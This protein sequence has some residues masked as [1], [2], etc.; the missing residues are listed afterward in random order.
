M[1]LFAGTQWDQPPRCE[2]CGELEEVCQ[3]P[4]PPAPRIP[5]EKQTAR[6]A[7]EKRK[8]GKLV[9]VVRGLPAEGNDL[10]ELLTKLKN[11][12]GAGGTLK[13]E[14]LEIQGDQLERVRGCLTQ[15]GFRVK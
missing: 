13:D 12:C 9:T 15:I 8:K 2:R 4:P 10:P 3:C 5:P 11:H 7:V 1:R 6:I 14:E